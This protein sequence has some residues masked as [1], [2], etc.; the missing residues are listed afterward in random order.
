M[1]YR[2][3]EFEYE[4]HGEQPGTEAAPQSSAGKQ[5]RKKRPLKPTRR[6]SRKAS[7]P[8]HGICGRQ[9]RRWLR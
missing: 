3:L 2:D 1:P 4:L 9:N 8:G 5:Y 7:T 6:K